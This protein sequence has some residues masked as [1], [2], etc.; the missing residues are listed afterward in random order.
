[1]K[2]SLTTDKAGVQ[3]FLGM[4]QY[5]SKFCHNLSETVL[6]LRDLTKE[7]SVFLWS[8]NH[9]NAFNSAKDLIASTTALRYYDATLPVTLQVDASEDAIGGVLLQNDQPVCFTSHTLN[10]TE[11]NYAQIEKEC[12]AIV[13]CMAKWHQYLYGKHDITVHTDHYPL[14]T[15]FKKPLSKAPRRLQRMML[16]LQKYQFT[17]RYKKGKELYVA[18]TLSRAAARP[19]RATVT[20]LDHTFAGKQECEVF[21]LELEE[22]DLTP[23]R[24]TADTLK[25]I[26][27]ETA[28][29][30]VLTALERV[31]T[32][33]WP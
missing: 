1:M 3:R 20:D 29:D 28:K 31:V 16:K 8:N 27:Q 17:V 11:K 22:M 2:I 10:S 5:L 19:S 23:N 18:D 25:R 32:S 15:I 7:D 6:P 13:S 33:G 26:R 12:L 21:R 4:C 30:P 9:E 24:V 14:E